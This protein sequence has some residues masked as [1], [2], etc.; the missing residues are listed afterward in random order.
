MIFRRDSLMRGAFCAPA[1][2]LAL[3]LA[4]GCSSPAQPA[5]DADKVISVSNGQIVVDPASPFLTH[6][7]AGFAQK[8]PPQGKQFWVVGQ[9]VALANPSDSLSGSSIQW[10]ELDPDLTRELGLRL[11]RAVEGEA[12]GMAELPSDYTGQI[13][14]GEEV[15]VALYGLRSHS[16]PGRV[17]SVL[18]SPRDPDWVRVVLRVGPGQEWYPGNNCEVAFPLNGSPALIPTTALLH[19]GSDEYVL[20]RTGSNSFYPHRII[21]LDTEGPNALI[22]GPVTAGTAIVARGAILLK[23]YLHRILR[24]RQ[25]GGLGEDG[26]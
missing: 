10:S 17:V 14:R 24:A 15:T 19:E 6:L 12:Y 5:F 26:L 22:M 20:Q 1:A 3:S 16:G 23:P 7:E 4:G 18:P 25:A 2:L 8:A 11:G 21:I 9:I 13:S